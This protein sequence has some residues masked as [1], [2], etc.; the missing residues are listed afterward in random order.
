MIEVG[1]NSYPVLF[2]YNADGKKDLLIG[3]FGYYDMVGNTTTQTSQLTLYINIG[4][5]SQPVYSLVTRNLG[6]VSVN[7][8]INAMPTVG[9]LDG[10][11]DTD[12]LIGTSIGQVHWLKNSAGAG[13]VCN[14]STFLTSPFNFTTT[15]GTAA[16]Q[17]FDIN[18][19][20]K[21]DLLIGTRNGRI[22]YYQNI[23]STTAPSFSL[24]TASFGNV[25]V[26]TNTN[27]FGFDAYA[28]PFFYLDG[29]VTKLLVGSVSGQI[30]QYQVPT[31]LTNSCTLISNNVNGWIEGSQ[32]TIWFEDIN[33]DGLRDAFLGNASGG[34]SFFSSNSPLVALNELTAEK[35]SEQITLFPNPAS[36]QIT[37]SINFIEFETATLTIYNLLGKVVL[38]KKLSQNIETIDLKEFNSGIYVGKI[39]IISHG[40]ALCVTKK[41]IKN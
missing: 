30:F 24:I 37:V 9:D 28:T 34:L 33:N 2:D 12:I 14:F 39:N 5:L 6:N 19:D 26:T 35:L 11:G 29:G 31:V 36:N 21:L 10:D 13:N 22:A 8:L 3:T 20:G 32:S 27:Q 38:S 18:S 16:P 17:L 23:G 1:Q 41:I 15:S 4:T 7:N 40:K 25:N